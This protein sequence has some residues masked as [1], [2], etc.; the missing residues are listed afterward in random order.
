MQVEQDL[1]DWPTEGIR[2]RVRLMMDYLR[3]SPTY[4]LARRS[5]NGDLSS[6]EGLLLPSDFDLV[7]KTYDEY[8]DINQSSFDDWWL[9]TG[10]SLYGSEFVK[11]SVKKIAD[12]EQDQAYEARFSRALVDFFKTDRVQEGNGPTLILAVPLG[13]KKQQ[14]LRE[15]AKLIDDAGVSAAPIGVKKLARPHEGE[16]FRLFPLIR[17]YLLLRGRVMNPKL[18]LWR[19]GVKHKVSPRTAEGLDINAK[20]LDPLSADQRIKMAILT[21]RAL[22]KAKCVCENAARGK[23]LSS[24]PIELPEFDYEDI[25]HRLKAYWVRYLRQSAVNT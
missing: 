20:Q 9:S 8:G 24:D 15:I 22:K 13:M 11:P 1:K 2:G 3:L 14:A 17:G 21:S 5:R 12:I 18:E 16:R 4:E 7:L 19:R 6:S 10:I 25:G 23:F